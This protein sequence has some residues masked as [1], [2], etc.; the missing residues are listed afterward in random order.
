MAGDLQTVGRLTFLDNGTESQGE[1]DLRGVVVKAIVVP[2]NW[3][4]AEI[5]F[6][7]KIGAQVGRGVADETDFLP[8]PLLIECE[9]GQYRILTGDES[10]ASEGLWVVHALSV[11]PSDDTTPVAQASGPVTLVLVGNTMD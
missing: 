8:T 6:E 2:S 10:G 1:V 3:T 9:P 11:N 4:A 5:R 7:S